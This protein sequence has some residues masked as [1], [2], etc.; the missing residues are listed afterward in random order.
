MTKKSDKKKKDKM[1][2]KLTKVNKENIKKKKVDITIKKEKPKKKQLNTNVIFDV[3]SSS[4]NL[5]NI[6][7]L[8]NNNNNNNNNN[9]NR[10]EKSK[11]E[12]NGNIKYRDIKLI[13]GRGKSAKVKS[14]SDL[15]IKEDILPEIP[16]DVKATV[17]LPLRENHNID[18]LKI[19][20]SSNRREYDL[21][22]LSDYNIKTR[23][24]EERLTT[25][26]INSNDINNR[27]NGSYVQPMERLVEKGYISFY[28]LNVEDTLKAITNEHKDDISFIVDQE[29]QK[30][31]NDTAIGKRRKRRSKKAKSV[32][33]ND[34]GEGSEEDDDDIGSTTS[35]IAIPFGN[36][37]SF[38]GFQLRTGKNELNE[39]IEEFKKDKEIRKMKFFEDDMIEEEEEE[40]EEDD[41]IFDQVPEECNMLKQLKQA[42]YF[43][44]KHRNEIN[45]DIANKI[46]KFNDEPPLSKEYIK[47]YRLRPNSTEKLCSNGLNCLFN[48]C[49]KEENLCYIGKVFYTPRQMEVRRA[50]ELNLHT[51]NKEWYD[52]FHEK[53]FNGLCIDCVLYKFTLLCYQN[54]AGPQYR[55]KVTYQYLNELSTGEGKGLDDIDI[56]EYNE[57]F[58]KSNIPHRQFNYFTVKKEKKEYGEHCMLPVIMNGK[59]TGII[60][61]VP[62]Y[63]ANHRTPVI[64]RAKQIVDNQFKK[65]ITNY[66]ATTGE[67]F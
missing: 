49:S 21:P 42:N 25:T 43:K 37:L 7:S 64:I 47:F 28:N 66:L 6:P 63:S 52:D 15:T 29:R 14:P 20:T 9:I 32:T 59:P 56:D 3:L 35:R 27:N 41:I 10:G 38:Y 17:L 8:N 50:K 19:Q 51:D 22:T 18:T 40:H 46:P 34:A 16:N 53:K 36:I 4:S 58:T 33:I 24:H 62:K 26:L 39:T 65:Y 48:L 44:Y 13:N 31:I 60:G 45:R 1:K 61:N 5:E 67:D 30:K 57:F 55:K 12:K 54:V 2:E 23:K 11:S